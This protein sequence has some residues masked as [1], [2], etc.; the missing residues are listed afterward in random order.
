MVYT[1]LTTYRGADGEVAIFPAGRRDSRWTGLSAAIAPLI[2]ELLVQ[3]PPAAS[4][5]LQWTAKVGPAIYS[6]LFVF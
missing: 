3:Q 1:P 6:T 2:A 4:T 5:D